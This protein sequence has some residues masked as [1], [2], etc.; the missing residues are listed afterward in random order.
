MKRRPKL[1][2]VTIA[3]GV[4]AALAIASPVFGVSIKKLVKKEVA[5]QISKAKGP[6]GVNGAN[7]A[8]GTARAYARVLP[9][10]STAC[11]PGCTFSRAK[12]VSGVTHPSTGTYCVT[13][14]GIDANQ[15]PPV[16]S[17]DWTSTIGPEGNTT[18]MAYTCAGTS[19]FGV[20]T[21][22][23]SV[24]GNA[25]ANVADDVGFTIVIP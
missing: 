14:P 2:T 3:L 10:A 12:G 18:A 8:N 19:S 24:T 15:V 7:G 23:L 21:E 13:A 22:R 1:S 4:I 25:D 20:R 16:V 11:A 9:H 17:V 5:K 6:A